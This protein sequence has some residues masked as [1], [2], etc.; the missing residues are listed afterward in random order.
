MFFFALGALLGP[1]LAS[2]WHY[3]PLLGRFWATSARLGGHLG[4]MLRSLRDCLTI[5]SDFGSI[6]IGFGRVWG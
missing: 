2:C 4:R 3:F 6:L 5:C 1:K